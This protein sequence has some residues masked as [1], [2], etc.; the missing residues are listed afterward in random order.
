MVTTLRAALS[1]VMLAG[2]YV[3]AVGLAV[4]LGWLSVLAFSSDHVRGATYLALFALV[5]VF[6]VVS[7]LWKVARAKAAPPTGVEVP[8]QSAPELWTVVRELATAAHTRAP[9]EIRLVPDVNAAVSEEARLLGLVGGRRR[10]YVGVPLLQGLDVAMLRSVLAHELGHY[11]RNHTRLGPLTYR[12]R[13]M[14]IA[15]VQATAGTVVGWLLL[16]YARL[17]LLVS[18]AVS[19][20]QELEADEISVAVAGRAVAQEAMRESEVVSAAWQHYTGVYVAPAFEVGLAPAAPA[21]FGGFDMLLRARADE[22][23]DLRRQE[24]DA[25]QS[26]W[27]S[28]P[29]HAARIRAMDRMTDTHR[30]RDTRRATLLIPGFPDAAA[31]VAE[32]ALR[33]EDRQRLD[34]PALGAAATTRNRQRV[35][36]GVYRAAARLA[37]LPRA[38]LA[39]VL[40]LVAQG[41]GPELALELGLAAAVPAAAVPAAPAVPAPAVAVPA[42]APAASVTH[43]AAGAEAAADD[44]G[45]LVD[46][47]QVVVC[48]AAVQA[49]IARWEQPW[50]GG[51]RLVDLAGEPIDPRPLAVLA[52]DPRTVADARRHLVALRVDVDRAGQESAQADALGASLLAGVAS[53][54]VD[55]ARHDVLVLD[56]GLVLVPAPRRGSGKKRLAALVE[57]ASVGELAARYRYLPFEEVATSKVR[58]K[59]PLRATL[60]LKRGGTVR[61]RGRYGSETLADNSAAVLAAAVLSLRRAP[62]KPPARTAA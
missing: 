45:T 10:M 34:W 11:S 38:T 41:R 48:S 13:A 60:V 35:A 51:P 3:V 25:T 21:F 29:S 42:A 62:A 43:P 15:T 4:L 49:G 31:M 16:G 14:V 39:T 36:D 1:L 6:G 47:L 30:A 40:G 26:R 9:D 19:R 46:A 37:G 18:A 33:F 57:G 50:V 12:G 27:D 61:L 24:P 32:G 20:R 8:P 59:V 28:H 54:S 53:V 23:A 55:G 44:T 7:A 58:G 2:F 52:A 22:L 5:L 17:Y 56:E